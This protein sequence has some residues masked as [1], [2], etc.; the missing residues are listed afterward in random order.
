[1]KS[2][3]SW[4]SASLKIRR[5]THE[6]KACERDER[7]GGD[8]G[9]RRA[10]AGAN[11]ASRAV[12][13]AGPNNAPIVTTVPASSPSRPKIASMWDARA[14]RGEPGDQQAER[15][16]AHGQGRRPAAV[17][18]DQRNGEDRRI[19]DRTPGENLRELE[20]Q[21][22]AP[23]TGHKILES[24]HRDDIAAA[25]PSLTPA[26]PPPHAKLRYPTISKAWREAGCAILGLTGIHLT[27]K[28][29]TLLILHL[30]YL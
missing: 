7:E 10:I 3:A 23:G 1:V 13:C 12:T 24:G 25:P 27:L 11:S 14:R 16:T 21:D 8:D 19:V 9:E 20:H 18:R 5:S 15:K 6:R 28:Q 4:L 2:A 26:R 22:G 17:G 29:L 30:V